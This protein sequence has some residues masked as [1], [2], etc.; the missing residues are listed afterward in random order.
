MPIGDATEAMDTLYPFFRLAE[1]GYEVV[2]AGPEARLYHM[3]LHEIPPGSDVPWDITREMPGYHIQATV[4]FRDVKPE[5]Y[6]GLFLSGGRAPEYLRYDADLM[7]ITKHFVEAKKPIAVV[8][9]GI[10]IIAAAGGLRGGRRATTVGKCALDITQTGGLYV[11][12]RC[13]V[14]GN[15]V[16]AG[17]WHDY[18][19]PFFKTFLRKMRESAAR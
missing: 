1:E 16:S 6:V 13:V 15:L 5:E 3:V 18:D 2:V 4:A 9:H 19:T 7:R 12:E 10:E 14:D 11:G 17:T 8:C